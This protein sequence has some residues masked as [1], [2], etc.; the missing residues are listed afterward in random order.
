MTNIFKMVAFYVNFTGFLT[1]T[2][3][4]VIHDIHPTAESVENLHKSYGLD[5]LDKLL[6]VNI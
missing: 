5:K 4:S 2:I 6:I 3:E 1:T